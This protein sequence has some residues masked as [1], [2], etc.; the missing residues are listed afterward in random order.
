ML[1]NDLQEISKWCDENR[2]VINVEKTKIMIVKTW[3]KWQHLDKMD[4][5]ICMKGDTLKVVES[6]KLLGFQVDNLLVWKVRVQTVHNMFARKLAR[7]FHIK[8]GNIPEQLRSITNE[9]L[10]TLWGHANSPER[11]YK[12][13]RRAARIITDYE[14]RAPSDPLLEQLNWPSLPERMKYKQSWLVLK[15]VN[16]LAPDY[17]CGLFKSV[18]NISTRTT[19]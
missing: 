6:E 11:M 14:Y 10:S 9:L 19:R 13:Q 2:M 16:W 1:N 7:L 17:I 8:Q 18:S 4:I 5:N 3:Q 12:L 15:A